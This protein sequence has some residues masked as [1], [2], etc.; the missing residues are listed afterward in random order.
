MSNTLEDDA[1]M[2]NKSGYRWCARRFIHVS[3]FWCVQILPESR[4]TL[5]GATHLFPSCGRTRA[6]QGQ[7]CNFKFY[8]FIVVLNIVP[9]GALHVMKE[10][11]H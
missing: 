1:A 11:I 6:R 7:D 3:L 4:T 5:V 9:A 10:G 2:Y 8:L